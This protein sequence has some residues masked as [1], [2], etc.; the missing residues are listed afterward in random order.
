MIT[1]ESDSVKIKT[2]R[3]DNSATVEF[4]I[5]EYQLENIKELVSITDKV[6]KVSVEVE[7]EE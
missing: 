6:M 3:A 5:G 7:L 4:T 1:F 2:G